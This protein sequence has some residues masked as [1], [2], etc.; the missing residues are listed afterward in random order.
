MARHFGGGAIQRPPAS[1]SC[2]FGRKLCVNVV[3][4]VH[5]ARYSCAGRGPRPRYSVRPTCAA[6]RP[7]FLTAR[8]TSG[9]PCRRR[10]DPG[11]KIHPGSVLGALRCDPSARCCAASAV[12]VRVA[13]GVHLSAAGL[14]SYTSQPAFLIPL[15]AVP[16]RPRARF[17][18]SSARAR[19]VRAKKPMVRC[20]IYW[21]GGRAT[22][23][24]R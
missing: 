10:D 3:A 20:E 2:A 24:A 8:P 9:R 1:V 14:R 4:P 5:T 17:P 18:P 11:A 21:T 22:R 6:S 16:A 12:N 7:T 15:L 23:G 13:S 19:L